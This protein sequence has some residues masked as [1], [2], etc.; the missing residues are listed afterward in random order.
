MAAPTPTHAH[1]TTTDVRRFRFVRSFSAPFLLWF[2]AR[3]SDVVVNRLADAD[4]LRSSENGRMALG[5]GR[6]CTWL[7]TCAGVAGRLRVHDVSSVAEGGV[8]SSAGDGGRG[9]RNLSEARDARERTGGR[10][11]RLK[12][13]RT[14]RKTCR[15]VALLGRVYA[16][17]RRLSRASFVGRGSHLLLPHSYGFERRLSLRFPRARAR[18]SLP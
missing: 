9:S 7:D 15:C 2:A 1:A 16:V 13:C 10:A 6:G 12:R 17:R 4:A 18:P 8:S 3:T 5:A 11:T 14:R